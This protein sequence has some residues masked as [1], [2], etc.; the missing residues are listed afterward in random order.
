MHKV[1]QLVDQ[2][3]SDLYCNIYV[4]NLFECA[5]VGG[6]DFTLQVDSIWARDVYVFLVLKE[7]NFTTG[8]YKHR[9][10]TSNPHRN[11]PACDGCI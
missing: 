4:P 2:A 3:E 7:G 8:V 11:M 6:S 9:G 1:S 5:T 10:L